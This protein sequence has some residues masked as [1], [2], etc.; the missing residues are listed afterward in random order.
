MKDSLETIFASFRSKSYWMANARAFRDLGREEFEMKIPDIT[1]QR[2]ESLVVLGARLAAN[3]DSQV[4]FRYSIQRA[5]RHWIQQ[6]AQNCQ[7]RVLLNNCIARYISIGLTLLLGVEGIPLSQSLLKEVQSFDRHCL[8]EMLGR[9]KPASM[10][11]CAF[12]CRQHAV[13]RG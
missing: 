12:R 3:G 11:W 2:Q 10:G 5:W 1:F 8:R 6:R 9:R 7:T 4:S 13:L